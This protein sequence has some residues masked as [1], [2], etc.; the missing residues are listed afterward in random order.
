MKVYF[1]CRNT[2]LTAALRVFT[3]EKLERLSRYLDEDSEVHVIMSVQK[4]HRE[5]EMVISS[6]LRSFTGTAMTDDLFAAVGL[7][8]DKLEKQLRRD[9]RR[10]ADR[11]R[12]NSRSARKRVLAGS[13]R[14]GKSHRTVLPLVHS[15]AHAAKPMSVEEAAE[16]LHHSER[17]F[18][19]FRNSTSNRMSVVYR[20]DD[21]QI[22]LIEAD[23]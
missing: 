19:I 12:R 23:S 13:S 14:D 9:K 10:R 6:L 20:R 2:R 3:E 22:G 8:V 7:V 5:A 21:G 15:E 18:L 11:R 1:T 16:D 17:E 4:H